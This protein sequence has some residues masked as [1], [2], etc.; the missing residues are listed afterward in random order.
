M[1]SRRVLLFALAAILLSGM[2]ALAR[3]AFSLDGEWECIFAE[4]KSLP[5]EE[6][7][8][9]PVQVPSAQTWRPQGP[10]TLWYRRYF[11]LPPSWAGERI[12]LLLGGVKYSQ[13]VLLN[14][15]EI[16]Q[17]AGGFE[18]TEYDL[19]SQAVLGEENELLVAVGDWT[20]LLAPGAKVGVPDASRDFGSWVKEGLLAPIGSRGW[21]V[22]IWGHVSVEARS[23]VW[24]AD[25][26]VAPSVREQMLRVHVTVKNSGTSEERTV[27]TARVATG[28]EGPWLQ[29]QLVTVPAGREQTVILEAPWPNPHLWS[30]QDP[31]LYSLV[32]G[33]RTGAM[34]DSTEVKFGFREFWIEGDRFLLNGTPIHLLATGALPLPEYDADP[35]QAYELA[36]SAGCAAMALAG[37][38]WPSQW[39]DAADAFGMLLIS[40]SALWHLATSYALSAD[41]FWKNAREHLAAQVKAQRNHPS[42]VVWGAENE[43]LSGG[44]AKARGVEQKVG[45]LADLVRKADPTRPVMFEGDADPAGKASII[46]L[47]YP[48]ELPNW[49]LWPETAYW[50]DA[51]VRLDAYPK[52]V[53]QWDRRKPLYLG[54]FGRVPASQVDALSVFFGDAAY[55]NVASYWPRAQAARWEMQIAAARDAGVSGMCPWSMWE[56]P[57]CP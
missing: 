30:P 17:R 50:L 15:E 20:A 11:Y 23:R 41:A 57:R 16:G 9:E 18:P 19:T 4:S 21:E 29:P 45:E 48:H 26:F 10:H 39:Y 33:A 7:G 6:A 32:A 14:G 27:V 25:A 31:H 8:W 42:I 2:P 53:W 52:T 38:P 34:G 54:E 47:H 55:P 28:G 51:P 43:L 35:T 56:G 3:Q 44:G 13:R 46:N 12:V 36:Q 1:T 49:Q 24:V 5:D 37:E 22:G 40:E